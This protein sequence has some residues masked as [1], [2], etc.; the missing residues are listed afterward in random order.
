[1]RVILILTVLIT[2]PSL[3]IYLHNVNLKISTLALQTR[4]FERKRIFLPKQTSHYAPQI[5][6]RNCEYFNSTK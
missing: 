1:M 2:H 6:G 4:I 3:G 5:S